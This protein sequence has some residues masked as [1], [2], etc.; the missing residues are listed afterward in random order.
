[1]S[2]GCDQPPTIGTHI[3]PPAEAETAN[4]VGDKHAYH[5]VPP[6]VTSNARMP[7]IVCED[8]SG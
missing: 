4:P 7:G 5:S 1:M 6:P 8:C 2:L 3:T